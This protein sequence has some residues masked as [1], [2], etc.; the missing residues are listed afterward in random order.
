MSGLRYNNAWSGYKLGGRVT[1]AVG[2]VTGNGLTDIIGGTSEGLVFIFEWNGRTYRRRGLISIGRPVEVVAL[3]DTD[4]DGINEII[5]GTTGGVQ[6]WTWTGASF[7]QVFRTNVG[8]ITSIAVG[9]F[10][11]DGLEE[12]AVTAG[13]RVL[14][15]GFDGAEYDLVAELDFDRRVLVGAGDLSGNGRIELV[16]AFVGGRQISLFRWTGLQF[17]E[18]RSTNIGRTIAGPL[19]VGNVIDSFD[20][21]IVVGVD[22]GSRFVVLER[23]ANLR[24]RFVSSSLGSQ[25]Q[26][27]AAG[28]WDEDGDNELIVGTS[29]RVFIFQWDRTF[30]EIARINV[31]G[32]ISS[33]AAGDVN[34][35]GLLEIVVGTAQGNIFILRQQFEAST[36]FLIQEE[37]TIPNGLPDAIKVAE[38]RVSKTVVQEVRTIPGKIIVKGFFVVSVLYV[39]KPDRKVFEF[40][41]RVNFV[42][43]I[44]APGIGRGDF[45]DVDVRVEFINTRFDPS[46]PRE[47]EVVIVAEIRVFDHIVR[48]G[49]TLVTLA[50]QYNSTVEE[51]QRIN[52]LSGNQAFAGQKLKL[53]F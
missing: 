50:Q 19:F 6:V 13:S 49:E 52:G 14:V 24:E 10:D 34:D 30:T 17:V 41:E 16:V 45:A 8:R 51:I 1:V 35:D 47:V 25:I 44:E 9:D 3:G 28:D 29:R 20:E 36:Q 4:G 42:H 23:T 11:N 32:T 7:Q 22:S 46:M 38:A 37:L 40:D 26:G 33:V 31:E 53:P 43:F 15:Y 39:G 12:I 5:V 2:D 18:V 27:F 48:Q 21:E